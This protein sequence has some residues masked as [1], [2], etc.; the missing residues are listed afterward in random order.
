MRFLPPIVFF[1]TAGLVH[2]L[3]TT[4]ADRV[5]LFPMMDKLFPATAGDLAAQG[6]KTVLVLLGIGGITLIIAVFN[7]WRD[8][9]AA[10]EDTLPE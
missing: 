8:R 9:Q 2:Y 3:N 10:S 5:I 1:G 7:T 6:E 4:R